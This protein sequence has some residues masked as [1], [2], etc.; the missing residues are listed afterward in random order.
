MTQQIDMS[1]AIKITKRK[2]GAGRYGVMWRIQFNGNDTPLRITKSV[3][4]KYGAQQT[5][6]V[7]GGEDED[8]DLLFDSKG[9]EGAMQAIT[10]IVRAA[11]AAR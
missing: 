3:P 11:E 1:G 2:D 8:A 10:E 4:A 7:I 5:F 6:D 9:L